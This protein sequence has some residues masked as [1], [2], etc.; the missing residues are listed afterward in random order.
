[1]IVRKTNSVYELDC[2]HGT[3]DEA[4]K[5]NSENRF[6]AQGKITIEHGGPVR[7]GEVLPTYPA[8]YDG[9]AAGIIMDLTIQ[10][11][12]NGQSNSQTYHLVFNQ[13]PRLTKCL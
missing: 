6:H 13:D 4:L 7:P 5:L 3:I 11:Q 10:Y 12:A 9:I 2:A 8:T 1:M